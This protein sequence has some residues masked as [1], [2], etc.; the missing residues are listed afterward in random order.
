MLSGFND[1]FAKL[2]PLF[3]ELNKNFVEMAPVD[4]NYSIDEAIVHYDGGHSCTQF[5][6]GKPI[7]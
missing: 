5:I 4:R 7:R 2:R 3:H 6:R 1:Q